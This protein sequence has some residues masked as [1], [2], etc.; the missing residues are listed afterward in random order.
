[1]EM[2]C[3]L[4]ILSVEVRKSELRLGL[5]IVGTSRFNI[6][7]AFALE[8]LDRLSKEIKDFCGMINE[9]VLRKNFILIYEVMCCF[10]CRFWMNRLISDIHS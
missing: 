6:Q 4:H 7:P 5:Y 2:E 10:I 8:V 9:E 1:M 3:N